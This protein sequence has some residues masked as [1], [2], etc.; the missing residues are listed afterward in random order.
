MSVVALK[1]DCSPVMPRSRLSTR[2]LPAR[3]LPACLFLAR[4][5]LLSL[6]MPLALAAS[7]ADDAFK[8]PSALRCQFAEGTSRTYDNGTYK[9]QFSKPLAFAITDI[10]L[11]GQRAQLETNSGKGSLRLVR[12]VG[13]NHFLEVVTEG[14]LN[15]TTVYTLVEPGGTF[16]AVHSRHFGLFGEPVIAQ[17]TGTCTAQ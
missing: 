8:L 14:F 16:P 9:Q 5:L 12:A 15:V 6:V 1:E 3:L 17:Y 2:L 7:A 11:D 4:L 10:D 13:A